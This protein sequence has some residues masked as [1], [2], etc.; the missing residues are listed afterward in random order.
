VRDVGGDAVHVQVLRHAVPILEALDTGTGCPPITAPGRVG[1]RG[2][3][4][5]FNVDD[6]EVRPAGP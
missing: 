3:D 1:I 5:D 6:F 2:D 4:T